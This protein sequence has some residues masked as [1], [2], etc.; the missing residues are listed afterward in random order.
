MSVRLAGK[1]A[2]ITGAASGIGRATAIRFASEGARVGLVDVDGAGLADAVSA[3]EAAGGRAIALPADVC[4][5]AE[6]SAAVQSAEQ[7]FGGLDV[8]VA[9]A[10]VHL[11]GSRVRIHELES[12]V[13]QRMIDVNLTGVF[14]TCKYAIRALLRNG[15]G[16]VICTGSPTGLRGKSPGAY[17]ASK[18]G[19]MSLA[20]A[21][22]YEYAPDG[23]RVN[24]VVP[25][26]T[27][28]RLVADLMANDV[29]REAAMADIPLGRPG[30]PDEIASIMV[31][32]A[33][34]EAS[35]ATGALFVVDGGRTAV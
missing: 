28:T 23:I 24:T 20:R 1:R 2:V 8:A 12:D 29:S 7:M 25:G 13:W 11:A 31:F 14:L 27:E 3:I 33:S 21:I 34:D 18:G 19:V 10:A 4:R 35:Y 30:T 6:I 22:A 9:N 16:S 26:L 5:E 15:G 17:S 32:L